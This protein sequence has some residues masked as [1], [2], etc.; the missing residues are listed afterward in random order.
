MQTI[1]TKPFLIVQAGG[2]GSRLR[3]HTW[4]KPKCLVSVNG[5]PILYHLFETFKDYEFIIIGDYAFDVLDSYLKI[6]KPT[7]S[8]KLIKADGKGTLSGIST[9]LELIPEKHPFAIVWSDLLVL[10]RPDWS[11]ITDTP[12]ICTTSS[13][14][15]RWSATSKTKLEEKPSNKDGIPGLFYF[16]N[17]EFMPSPPTQGEFVKW[18][19]I[20]ISKFKL[21]DCSELQE[22]GD[23]QTI[24]SNN[25]RLGFSR[26][27][28][29]VEVQENQVIKT[30]I[31]K[32]YEK[33]HKEE[34]EWYR[35]MNQLG[36]R[37]IPKIFSET[38][39]TMQRIIGQHAYQIYDLSD[40]EKRAV[41]ADY[42]DTLINLHDLDSS[43]TEASDIL[44]TY[45]VKTSNRVNDVSKI[46]PGFDKSS[47]TVNG[48][49]CKNIFHEKYSGHLESIVKTLTPKKFN[50]IHG[51]PTFSNTIIDKNLR[52]WFIDPRGSFAKPGIMGDPQYD[53]AKLYYS[54]IGGYDFFNRRKF[55]LHVDEDTV[56]ILMEEPQLS[57][58]GEPLFKDYFG[59]NLDKIKIIHGLIWLALSGYAKDDIDSIIGSFYLGLYWLETAEESY[60]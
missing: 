9:A 5:K 52:V 15:C 10:T 59:Q 58:V 12:V 21:L 20:N 47:M 11:S 33:V 8:Y 35:S 22:L 23:F 17:K 38:P 45:L 56:E 60:S 53:F 26:F 13:F 7:I 55:K 39:L 29:K 24:E 57:N 16:P 14:T 4:N 54:A 40:R 43:P 27:F 51:D 3:H 2:R 49:K 46:I 36:F 25:D 37:R 28:N 6:N 32:D 18:V 31:D 48:K 1:N 42:I 41:L 50:P 19:S 34:V 44:E 30:V